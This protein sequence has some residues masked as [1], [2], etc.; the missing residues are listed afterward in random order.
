MR[1]WSYFG[2]IGFGELHCRVG[3]GSGGFQ[4]FEFAEEEA[5]WVEKMGCGYGCGI[6]P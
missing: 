6:G 3:N 1:L 5:E 4:R 2:A